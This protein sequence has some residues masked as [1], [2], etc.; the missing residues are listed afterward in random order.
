M[1]E[2]ENGKDTYLKFVL[3]QG[4]FPDVITTPT[5]DQIVTDLTN[6]LECG[7]NGLRKYR[8]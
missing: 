2:S 7:F 1:R 3:D 8:L 5:E 4:Y 6:I